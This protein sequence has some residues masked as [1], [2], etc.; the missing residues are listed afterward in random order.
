MPTAG[1]GEKVSHLHCRSRVPTRPPHPGVPARSKKRQ[2]R[3]P[4]RA[5]P[6]CVGLRGWG[7]PGRGQQAG[8][9]RAP[10][11]LIHRVLLA[12]FPDTPPRKAGPASSRGERPSRRGLAAGSHP[13]A[14]PRRPKP[15]RGEGGCGLPRPLLLPPGR[16]ARGRGQCPP[17]GPRV[18]PT[19]LCCPGRLWTGVKSLRGSDSPASPEQPRGAFSP[20]LAL[21]PSQGSPRAPGPPSRF[22]QS[23]PHGKG[24]RGSEDFAVS[25][26]VTTFSRMLTRVLV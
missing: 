23:G 13:A 10:V 26:V 14:K 3:K 5:A 8:I 1:Q 19:W 11:L 18:R 17:L 12:L 25:G 2:P 15:R 4:A 24:N 7:R 16:S 21:P 22:I 20:G 6:E 9:A